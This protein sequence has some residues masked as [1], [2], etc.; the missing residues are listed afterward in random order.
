MRAKLTVVKNGGGVGIIIINDKTRLVASNSGTFPM[1]VI[2]TED[3][4]EIL[5]YMNATE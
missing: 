3:S 5:A 1:T 4:A 2:T